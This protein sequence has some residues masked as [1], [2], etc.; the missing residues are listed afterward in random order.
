MIYN[1]ENE[2]SKKQKPSCVK[3]QEYSLE[4]NQSHVHTRMIILMFVEKLKNN[5]EIVSN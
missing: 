2:V 3:I 4:P 5:E 1:L